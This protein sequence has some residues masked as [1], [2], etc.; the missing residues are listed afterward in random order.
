MTALILLKDWQESQIEFWKPIDG[1]P[2]YDVSSFGRFR[3]YWRREFR[4]GHRGYATV[5]ANEFVILRQ[6]PSWQGYMRVYLY[7]PNIEKGLPAKQRRRCFFAHHLIAK[8]FLSNPSKLPE[9]NH[10]TGLK[11]DNRVGNLEWK[12]PEENKLHA[13]N[14]LKA[15]AARRSGPMLSIDS[16][17]EIR[18]Q[19]SLG[20]PYAEIGQAFSRGWRQIHN[21]VSR[22]AFA[23]VE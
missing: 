12:S 15:L 7:T 19:A 8:I 18:R 10:K 1:F 3:S 2:G 5:L 11:S 4:K 16:V 20:V 23:S 21:I 17:R 9:T 22:R 14:E 13:K 6:Y